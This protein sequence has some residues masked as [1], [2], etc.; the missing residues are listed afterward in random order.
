LTAEPAADRHRAGRLAELVSET[1]CAME[2]LRTVCRGV[3][4]AVL[5]RRGLTQALF[6]QLPITHPHAV[7]E[8][9]DT[10]DRRLDRAAEAAGYL[11]CVEVAPRDQGS[12]IRLRVE[13]ERLV[14]AVSG[15]IGWANAIDPSV[16]MLASW[17]HTRDRVAALDGTVDV[18]RDEFG[19][20]VTAV[21]PLDLQPGANSA[22]RPGP[23]SN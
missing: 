16:G 12:L 18:R 2:A 9:D 13:D 15:D 21:M 19:L 10:A 4:P 8:V 3:F 23:S 7:L 1:E 22:G 20:T 11:F 6:A 14:A 5:A 17:Q